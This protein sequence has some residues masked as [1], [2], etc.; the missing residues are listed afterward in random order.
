MH[1]RMI[2]SRILSNENKLTYKKNVKEDWKC[3]FFL[4]MNCRVW[5]VKKFKYMN[6]GIFSMQSI[7]V[8]ELKQ[9][10]A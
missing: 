10:R 4:H 6:A 1:R 9:R 3:N 8:Y 7:A 2:S 5:F